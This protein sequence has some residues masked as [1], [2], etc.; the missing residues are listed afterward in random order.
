MNLLEIGEKLQSTHG[1]LYTVVRFI[2]SGGQGEVYEVEDKSNNARYALKWYF[3][4]SATSY[5]KKLIE[6]L[7][8]RGK[9]DHR[10]LWPLDM[11]VQQDIFGYVM[12]LRPLEY[13]SIL[14]LMKRRVDTTFHALCMA[15]INLADSYQS[16]HTQGLCYRDISFGNLFFKPDDGQVLICDNDNVTVN[17]DSEGGTEGTPR[18]IAPEII[19][20]K[21]TPSTAT[22]LYSMA[23]LLFYMFMLHH[24]LE[25]AI[26]ANIRCMDGKAME[27]IYGK[28]P[29]FIWDPTNLTN[30]PVSGYQDNAI[31][32]WDIYPQYIKDL[33]TQAFTLGL[34][35]TNKRI[36]E[37]QWKDAIVR[38]KNSIMYCNYCGSQNFYDLQKVK[39]SQNHHCWQCK[40]VVQL[41]ARIKIG[42]Q[43]VMLNKDT[44]L[45]A[46]HIKNNYDFNDNQV[47]GQITTHPQQPNR[48]GLT[49]VSGENW[50]M[51]KPSGENVIVPPKKTVP[52]QADIKINF[53]PV[54]GIVK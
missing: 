4:N 13:K 24:P 45:F 44:K 3:K 54:E 46:H 31:I 41:P 30:R 19:V 25:G 50:T 10:F 47:I 5:Q 40:G 42:D 1:V 38:L 49:N 28:E 15:G 32:Y 53:G 23:V 20:E 6:G 9:P 36:V 12:D 26:E 29:I 48:W 34:H 11:V 7:V 17:M 52:L 35:D 51:T 21:A 18:F 39:K 22:D 14:D 8:S 43:L 16:L 27:K 33:F 2:A 37:I